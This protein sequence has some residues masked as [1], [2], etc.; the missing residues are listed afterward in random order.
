MKTIY[1]SAYEGD[2]KHRHKV[3]LP[4]DYDP[5]DESE[6]EDLA[7]ACAE[8]WHDDHDGWESSWPRVFTLYA[9]KTGPELAR[10][11]VD[12]EYTPSFVASPA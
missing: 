8:D 7:L 2:D 4:R 1:Y 9:D 6:I 3:D 5:S 12:R 10:R 11:S